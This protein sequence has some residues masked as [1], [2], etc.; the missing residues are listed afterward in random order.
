MGA[1]LRVLAESFPM[2]TNMTGFRWFLKIFAA[3]WLGQKQGRIQPEKLSYAPL[4][5]LEKWGGPEGAAAKAADASAAGTKY[6][7][8]GGPGAAQGPA[9]IF[10]M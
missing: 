1:H 7:A 3:L 9:E 10:Y 5:N 2:N 6:F 4:E 8:A